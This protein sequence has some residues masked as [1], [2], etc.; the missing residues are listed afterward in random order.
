MEGKCA[1]CSCSKALFRLMRPDLLVL[2]ICLYLHMHMQAIVYI[3]NGF[4][5]S[6][7]LCA[8]FTYIHVNSTVFLISK[9]WQFL[10]KTEYITSFFGH[11]HASMTKLLKMRCRKA[12]T[13]T[14]T[15]AVESCKCEVLYF[16]KKKKKKCKPPDK[17]LYPA[18]KVLIFFLFH[19]NICCGAY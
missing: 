12:I 8:K 16:L 9:K 2:C 10:W 17:T 11:L 5:I 6:V 7:S 4:W 1:C 15:I 14:I 13:A 19:E 18:K 3:C